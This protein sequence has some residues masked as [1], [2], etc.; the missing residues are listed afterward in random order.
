MSTTQ[1]KFLNDVKTRIQMYL[2]RS[3]ETDFDPFTAFIQ[4]ISSNGP[5][6]WHV[7][8]NKTK[9]QNVF[10][11]LSTAVTNYSVTNG[12]FRTYMLLQSVNIVYAEFTDELFNAFVSS[13]Y[14]VDPV[15]VVGNLE[16]AYSTQ[17]PQNTQFP[18]LSE[19]SNPMSP[20]RQKLVP[21]V[22]YASDSL[23]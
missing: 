23:E 14:G 4:T 19:N 11:N 3:L 5:I 9:I 22:L 20:L 6:N 16:N 13:A 21:N 12:D 8:A 10:T 17:P 15:T 2:Y 1:E 7:P 18:G